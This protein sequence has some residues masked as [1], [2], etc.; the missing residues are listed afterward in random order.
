MTKTDQH[1]QAAPDRG[2]RRGGRADHQRPAQRRHRRAARARLRNE[3]ELEAALEQQTPDIIIAN[4]DAADLGLAQV[5]RRRPAAAASDVALIATGA[6][7]QRGQDRRRVPRRRARPRAARPA[8]SRADDRAPRIR[9]ADDAPQRAPASRLR[10]ASPSGAAR[11][12]S[13]PRAI[14]SPTCTKACTCARTR[15]IWRCSASTTSRMS[16]ACR[17]ST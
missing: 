11:R 15:R 6:R 4:L 10:C 14:R 9:G 3:A 2:L 8:R 7:P 5:A 17:S 1:H 12:C 13:I 16:R